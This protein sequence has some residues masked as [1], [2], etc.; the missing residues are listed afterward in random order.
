MICASGVQIWYVHLE[1]EYDMCI[2]NAS[3]I[4]ASGMR[5]WYVHLE[6]EYDMCIWNASM[7]CASW[8]RV[9]YVHLECEYDMYVHVHLECEYDM[10][11]WNASMICA[12]GMRVWYVHLECKYDTVLELSQM[13]WGT[14]VAPAQNFVWLGCLKVRWSDDVPKWGSDGKVRGCTRGTP[15]TW[16]HWIW[17]GNVI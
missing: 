15:A 3:M 5:V 6:C 14:R 7:I 8:M 12:S 13:K 17:N 2:W 11:I 1:C 10:C 4:C 9:W 16:A